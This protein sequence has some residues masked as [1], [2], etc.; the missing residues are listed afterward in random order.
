MFYIIVSALIVCASGYIPIHYNYSGDGRDPRAVSWCTIVLLPSHIG[1]TI[2]N[3]DP[4]SWANYTLYLP[5]GWIPEEIQITASKNLTENFSFTIVHS[6]YTYIK[7]YTVTLQF[8]VSWAT[9]NPELYIGLINPKQVGKIKDPLPKSNYY[10][11]V[12]DVKYGPCANP[13]SDWNKTECRNVV[14]R[15]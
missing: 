5:I 13:I 15:L 1:F 7:A 8:A 4:R 9:M 12:I 10:C 2:H 14:A 11:Y 6:A 3:T